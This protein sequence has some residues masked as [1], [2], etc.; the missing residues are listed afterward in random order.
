[1]KGNLQHIETIGSAFFMLY[2]PQLLDIIA[3]E[4]LGKYN[5]NMQVLLAMGA[6]CTPEIFEKVREGFR[7]HGFDEPELLS[8]FGT[9]E[10]GK[11]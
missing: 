1:M 5:L 7:R 9:N 8:A 4:D 6:L 10:L 11:K 2:L 3:L